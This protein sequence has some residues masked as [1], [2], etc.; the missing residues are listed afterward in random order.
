MGLSTHA[1]NK[2]GHNQTSDTH[3]NTHRFLVNLDLG[4]TPSI[5]SGENLLESSSN[6]FILQV[7]EKYICRQTKQ[8]NTTYLFSPKLLENHAHLKLK[9]CIVRILTNG[10]YCTGSIWTIWISIPLYGLYRFFFKK[11]FLSQ[12]LLLNGMQLTTLNV[13]RTVPSVVFYALISVP[14][15]AQKSLIQLAATNFSFITF[16][17]LSASFLQSAHE[18]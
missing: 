12:K 7:R 2:Y 6:L 17:Q 14:S 4:K 13:V 5:F 8:Q 16:L 3:K 10:Q 11:H 9:I 15:F 18:E 1:E